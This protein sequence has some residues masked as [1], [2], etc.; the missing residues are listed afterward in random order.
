MKTISLLLAFLLLFI[1]CNSDDNITDLN[2]NPASIDVTGNWYLIEMS[3]NIPNS[4]TTGNDMEWQETYTFNQDSTFTKSRF[5]KGSDST[6]KL[7]GTYKLKATE[8]ERGLKLYYN[9]ESSIIGS[10]SNA[11]EEYLYFLNNSQIRSNWWACDGPGLLYEKG[12]Y[13]D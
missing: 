6:I 1:S 13:L 10:C 9:E 4:T 5:N 2:N 12:S 8:E 7:S 3:G 11:K